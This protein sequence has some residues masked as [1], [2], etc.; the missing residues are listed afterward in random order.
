MDEQT[1]AQIKAQNEE[2]RKERDRIVE[3]LCN[4]F[5]CFKRDFMGAPIRRALLSLQSGQGKPTD[6]CEIPYRADE[7]YWVVASKSEV[8]VSY[9][10]NFDNTTDR[11]LA[12]IFLLVSSLSHTLY[13]SFY[14]LLTLLLLGIFR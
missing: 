13:I 5:S 14:V 1:A 3:E 9:G 10:L 7:K 8:T 12:R 2:I 11:A 4:K 6:S